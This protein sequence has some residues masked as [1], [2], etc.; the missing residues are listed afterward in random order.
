MLLKQGLTLRENAYRRLA[1]GA[2]FA[3]CETFEK[4]RTLNRAGAVLGWG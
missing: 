4:R 2:Y 1:A 3:A